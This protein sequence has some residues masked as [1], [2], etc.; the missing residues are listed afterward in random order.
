[1]KAILTR[2]QLL[3]GV[4]LGSVGVGLGARA[5]RAFSIEP[6]TAPVSKAYGLACQPTAAPGIDHLQLIAD[7][8][9]LLQGEIAHGLKPADA[10]EVVVCPLCG[11]SIT[12]TA[13]ASS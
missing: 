6:M 7:T 9:A 13:D 11:C 10:Q 3:A 12:V 2:R 1:M 5:A 4:A 8:R